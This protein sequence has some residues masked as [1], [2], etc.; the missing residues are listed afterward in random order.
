M[1]YIV[2]T[3]CISL[4]NIIIIG[5][6]S[7][8]MVMLSGCGTKT[9]PA[10]EQIPYCEDD[11]GLVASKPIIYLYPEEETSISVKLGK[12]QNLTCTY[13][14]YDDGWDVIANHD[15]SLID[16]KT[17]KKLYALYWEGKSTINYD[18]SE[19]FVV[20]GEDTITFLE[21]KLKILGLTDREAEEFIVY[22]LPQMQSNKYNYVKFV[23]PE[24]INSEMPLSF[25]VE[26]DTL[27]RV[28]MIWKPLD[29]FKEVSEQQLQTV[30]RKGFVA[31]EWGGVKLNS[32]EIK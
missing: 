32:N 1:W 7:I 13:P 16:T 23:T 19:G 4:R 24:E 30:E 3:K 2:A 9:V 14:R 5:I 28:M 8:I 25:S 22:W 17:G 26:P 12:T 6:L 15:G 31:V 18:T 11:G 20:R 27:I 21:E 10:E 29:S